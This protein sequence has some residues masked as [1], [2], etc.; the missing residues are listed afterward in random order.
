M[1]KIIILITV[2]F[3]T[4]F[5]SAQLVSPDSAKYF[6]DKI[7]S[8]KGKVMST[9]ETHGEK[10]SLVLNLGHPFPDQTFQVVIYEK[11]ISKFHEN[12]KEFF[13]DKELIFHGKVTLT[14]GKPSMMIVKPEQISI[15]IP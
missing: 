7:V 15:P 8:V 14:K 12:P 10:K 6:G 3:C 13:L 2:L 4:K 1:K 5:I 9:Y 11:D